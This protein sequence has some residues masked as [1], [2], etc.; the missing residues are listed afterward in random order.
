M[1]PTQK[2]GEA[3]ASG[4]FVQC[5]CSYELAAW[6]LG[7]FSGLQVSAS[8]LWH[9]VEQHGQVALAELSDQVSPTRSGARHCTGCLRAALGKLTAV[10][11]SGWGDGADASTPQNPER[12]NR[13]A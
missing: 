1:S 7:Q 2:I 13:L 8:S 3:G 11:W 5:L 6:L 12:Q 9:W 4:L 10:D